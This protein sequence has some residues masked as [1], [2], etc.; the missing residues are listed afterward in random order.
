MK[1]S[2]IP[3]AAKITIR[4]L[5]DLARGLMG[6]KEDRKDGGNPEYERALVELVTDAAGLPMDDKDLV[7]KEIGVDL[8]VL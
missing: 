8:K 7:A 5:I 6:P 4:E 3:F 1:M 2:P